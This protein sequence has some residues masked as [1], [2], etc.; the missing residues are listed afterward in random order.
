MGGSLWTRL[1]VRTGFTWKVMPLRWEL[2]VFSGLQR[3]SARDP[4]IRS[5]RCAFPI[6]M[7]RAKRANRISSLVLHRPPCFPAQGFAL[8][9]RW[10][11]RLRTCLHALLTLVALQTTYSPWATDS[12]CWAE[13]LE[14]RHRNTSMFVPF[15]CNRHWDERFLKVVRDAFSGSM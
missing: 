6:K 3:R 13:A 9:V 7:Y 1:P 4:N 11:R 10:T 8:G 15:C 2:V 12:R 5:L 14:H